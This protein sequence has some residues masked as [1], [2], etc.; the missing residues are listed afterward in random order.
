[1][2]AILW[3]INPEYIEVLFDDGLGQFMLI[4]GALLAGVGF[5]WLKKIVEIEI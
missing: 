3:A 4:G 5:Y 2:L 1:M